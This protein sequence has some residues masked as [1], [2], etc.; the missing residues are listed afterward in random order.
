[1]AE[2]LDAEAGVRA[3]DHASDTTARYRL[4]I[5]FLDS[6]PQGTFES[7]DITATVREREWTVKAIR[8]VDGRRRWEQLELI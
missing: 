2:L 4:R 7:G 1:M 5:A 3:S 6:R 8:D